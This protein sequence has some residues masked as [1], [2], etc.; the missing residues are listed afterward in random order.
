MNIFFYTPYSHPSPEAAAVRSYWFHKTLEGANHHVRILSNEDMFCKLGDSKTN[1]LWRLL[2]EIIAG[3][4]LFFRILCLKS[5]DR[6]ILSSPPFTTV[7]IASFAC[8][9]KKIP[10]IL[11]VRDLY[12]EV[13]IDA[14]L[15]SYEGPLTRFVKGVTR[16]VYWNASHIISVTRGLCHSITKYPVEKSKVHLITNGYDK[17][18][19]YPGPLE[20]KNDKFTL[21]FH[22][23]IG[24]VQNMQTLLQLAKSLSSHPEIEFLVIG[25]GSKLSELKN[26]ELNNIKLVDAIPYTQIPEVL[27]KCHVGLSFRTDGRIGRD[28]Y[29]V[30]V[31]EYI[32]T[33]LPVI[34]TP[35]CEMGKLISENKLGENFENDQIDEI[36]KYVL[37]LFESYAEKIPTTSM[38]HFSR[39]EVSR[40][41]LNLVEQGK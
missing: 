18:L 40:K 30:K 12:P 15:L 2:K 16:R 10:Y 34:M 8:K 29:P 28:A 11:D 13:Y 26:Q 31:F 35:I 17:D 27:R 22:G 20:K 14:G 7:V 5:T 4:E 24:K 9:I 36:K 19:F 23:K 37:K 3:V 39:Q 25:D 33:G 6:A 32:G 38:E 41:I 21:V 1:S